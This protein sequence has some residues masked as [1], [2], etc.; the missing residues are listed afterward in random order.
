MERTSDV[1][2]PAAR[3]AV[4]RGGNAQGSRTRWWRP[5]TGRSGERPAPSASPDT[6]V[7]VEWQYLWLLPGDAP[8]AA[9][10]PGRS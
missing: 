6:R 3:D 2:L 8:Y 5:I 7:E 9:R 4:R 10:T 1:H